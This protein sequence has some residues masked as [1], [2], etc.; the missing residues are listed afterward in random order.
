MMTNQKMEIERKISL[1]VYDNWEQGVDNEIATQVYKSS[2][3]G[4]SVPAPC[5]RTVK[6]VQKAVSQPKINSRWLVYWVRRCHAR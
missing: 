5:Q 2:Q 1:D 3:I 4:C 6:I